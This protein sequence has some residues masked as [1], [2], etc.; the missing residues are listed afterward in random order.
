MDCMKAN[1]MAFEQLLW[2]A[3]H[4][5]SQKALEVLKCTNPFGQTKVQASMSMSKSILIISHFL[6]KFEAGQPSTQR[7][8]TCSAS[9]SFALK[10]AKNERMARENSVDVDVIWAMGENL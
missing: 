2:I 8:P 1:A 7:V 3:K 9:S 10:K 4:F 6:C 5:L